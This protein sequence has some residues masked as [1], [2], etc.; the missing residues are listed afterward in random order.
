MERKHSVSEGCGVKVQSELRAER[1]S[2]HGEV[3]IGYSPAGS[4][5]F[6]RHHLRPS[7]R[8]SQASCCCIWTL[9]ATDCTISR[10]RR[11][12][13]SDRGQCL[14]SGV[15]TPLQLGVGPLSLCRQKSAQ[16]QFMM[17]AVDWPKRFR[18]P[19]LSSP[20]PSPSPLS[21]SLPPSLPLPHQWK[22][23]HHFRGLST[24]QQV[25]IGET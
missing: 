6:L 14:G 8:W 2:T 11:P 4:T 13:Q 21:F 23:G 17:A 16:D 19:P 18:S 10:P 12:P 1:F 5:A 7:S 9:V 24:I 15:A 20:C 25:R 3:Q 22:T